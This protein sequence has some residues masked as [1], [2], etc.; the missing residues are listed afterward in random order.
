MIQMTTPDI[1]FT[2]DVDLRSAEK[3]S[4][5]FR[6]GSRNVLVLDKDELTISATQLRHTFT[7]EESRKFKTSQPVRM[8]I[9]ALVDGKV[10]SHKDPMTMDVTEIFDKRVFDDE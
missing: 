5:T 10:I 6:Q 9:K 3:V 4:V 8:Q 2:V 7:E 1:V